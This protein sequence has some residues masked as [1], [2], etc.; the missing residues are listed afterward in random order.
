[1]NPSRRRSAVSGEIV[2][3]TG[4]FT[5]GDVKAVRVLGHPAGYF[6]VRS[7]FWCALFIVV[8]A[9]LAARRYQRG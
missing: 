5:L 1:M 3:A 4:A 2:N 8:F 9:P 6:A 7:L